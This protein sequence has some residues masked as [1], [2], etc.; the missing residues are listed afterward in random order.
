MNI[1]RRLK[2]Y[3]NEMRIPSPERVL[4]EGVEPAGQQNRPHRNKLRYGIGFG[5]AALACAAGISVFV[6][7]NSQ[8][9][10]YSG[11]PQ[12]DMLVNNEPG[13]STGASGDGVILGEAN[14]STKG[15]AAAGD[16]ASEMDDL[17]S[18]DGYYAEEEP[19]EVPDIMDSIGG[20]VLNGASSEYQAGTLT[21]GE[22]RDL[23]NWD[24]WLRTF[25]EEYMGQWNMVLNHRQAV[26]VHNGEEP[27]GG[28]HVRLMQEEEVL[29]EAVTDMSGYAYLFYQYALGSQESPTAL[30]VLGADGSWSSWEYSQSSGAEQTIDI[31]MEGSNQE[32]KVDLMYVIDTTGSMSDELEYLKAELQDVIK[33]AEEQTGAAIRTSVNFYRDEG[34]EYV[35]KYY[36]F[37]DDAAEVSELIGDQ[38]ANGGGDEPEAVH[39]ALANALHEHSW[40]QD[41][42]VKLLF[43][44]LDAPPHDEE[45]VKTELLRLMEEAA[46]MGVRII[47]VAAS[48]AGEYTQQLLRGMAVMTGGTFIFLDDNSGVGSGHTVTLKPEEYKS[49]YLNEMMIRIIGEYCSMDL[50]VQDI[51]ETT[52]AETTEFTQ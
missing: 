1:K 41:S 7:Q 21:G 2:D 35:V 30:E 47:P 26:Y 39:T 14:S 42:T 13:G 6:W 23:K 34:D 28:V 45:E 49:E 51:Q 17:A 32:L 4:P 3:V 22:I 36:D 38:S 25:S 33:R 40:S 31:R 48:G 9:N 52:E 44:V 43:L 16:A 19:A 11:F 8:N 46:A 10:L 18:D 5:G 24:N 50:E 29:Y 20:E 27:L 37:R 15:T 12:G